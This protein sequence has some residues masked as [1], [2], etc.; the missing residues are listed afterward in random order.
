MA[1]LLA[2]SGIG[3][4][5]IHIPGRRVAARG[6][7]SGCLYRRKSCGHTVQAY[8]GATSL[9]PAYLDHRPRRPAC[10]RFGCC[11]NWTS[12]PLTPGARGVRHFSNE[13]IS[14][15]K[16]RPFG[17]AAT[18]AARSTQSTTGVS[19]SKR[20]LTGFPPGNAPTR[21]HHRHGKMQRAQVRP[22]HNQDKTRQG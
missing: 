6:N 20:A 17:E 10:R 5:S 2:R 7:Q 16:G 1:A 18:T 14:Q 4:I 9:A 11:L 13:W 19:I 12:R 8:G 22:D 3:P 21:S 15:S